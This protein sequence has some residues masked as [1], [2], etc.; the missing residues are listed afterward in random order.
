MFDVAAARWVGIEDPDLVKVS[1]IGLE[2]D[3]TGGSTAASLTCRAPGVEA[4][5]APVV[6]GYT[7]DP[8]GGGSI[9]FR[10][11]PRHLRDP[12]RGDLSAP[13]TLARGQ[14]WTAPCLIECGDIPELVELVEV[15]SD[16]CW[17][18]SLQRVWWYR[19]YECCGAASCGE[20]DEAGCSSPEKS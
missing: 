4:G 14:V 19:T 15:E 13:R 18:P 7:V 9:T 3:M 11:R 2:Y 17:N 8:D 20:G 16:E 10:K 1:S 12:G 5:S 6:Y